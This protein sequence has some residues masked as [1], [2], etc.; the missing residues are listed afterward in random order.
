MRIG[1]DIDDTITNTE[2]LLMKKA[3][4]YD[5]TYK[6]VKGYK[7]PYDT[8]YTKRFYWNEKDVKDFHIKY[9]E[10]VY[11][12]VDIKEDAK[13]YINKL[14]DEGYEIYIVTARDK[15]YI[16]NPYMLS[17]NYLDN[18]G[19]KYDKLVTDSGNKGIVCNNYGI[20]ILIDDNAGNCIDAISCGVKALIYD[21][22]YTRQFMSLKRVHNW[23]EVYDTI[24][25]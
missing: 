25:K 2:Q 13:E 16:D 14:H 19:V 9:Y 22:P 17:K 11:L 23:K 7:D 3:F 12:N 8:S 20:D 5:K 15:E 6:D 10:Y 1:I 24:H 21:T 4:E 18:N